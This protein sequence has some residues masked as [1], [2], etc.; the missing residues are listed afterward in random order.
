MKLNCSETEAN[1]I[2]LVRH[3]VRQLAARGPFL[4]ARD[5]FLAARGRHLADLGR[6][7]TALGRFPATAPVHGATFTRQRLHR[8]GLTRH[9]FVALQR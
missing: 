5:R 4:A 9:E 2:Y 7:P 6:Q 3:A 8:T 1:E